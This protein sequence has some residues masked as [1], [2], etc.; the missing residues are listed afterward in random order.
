MFCCRSGSQTAFR[1][2]ASFG[3]FVERASVQFASRRSNETLTQPRHR[4]AFVGRCAVMHS[5]RCFAGA[6][7]RKPRVRA[8][9]A[10]ARC[11]AR[12]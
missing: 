12:A 3:A 10:C 11:L 8:I 7:A 1:A 4:A 9:R 5:N 2:R 6:A